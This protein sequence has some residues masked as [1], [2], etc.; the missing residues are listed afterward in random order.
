[1]TTLLPEKSSD[2]KDSPFDPWR[3]IA[4]IAFIGMELC[5]IVPWFRLIS[6]VTQGT[7]I[8]GSFLYFGGLLYASVQLA[9]IDRRFALKKNLN[10]IAHALLLIVS[11]WIGFKVLIPSGDQMISG[12]LQNGY[13]L[14]NSGIWIPAELVILLVVFLLWRHGTN[15]AREWIGP[16]L[17][18]RSFKLGLI[19]LFIYGIAGL[20]FPTVDLNLLLLAYLILSL[21]A[22]T[23]ARIGGLSKLSGGQRIKLEWPRLG[24]VFLAVFGAVGL[25]MVAVAIIGNRRTISFLASVISGIYLFLAR[26]FILI[27]FPVYYLLIDLIE[28]VFANLELPA[29]RH[30]YPA[31]CLM[32]PTLNFSLGCS[33]DT[34]CCLIC[35]S[36]EDCWLGWLSC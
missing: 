14:A 27:L 6:G 23:T 12:N 30:P 29:P 25:A 32:G 11:V 5:W 36:G 20:A 19:L 22:L 16:L 18:M 26:A 9:R 13:N 15:L 33:S 28:G 7:S 4:L 21:A 17:V 1:M 34:L 10:V 35:S 8:L 31:G 3:E 24:G 2:Q